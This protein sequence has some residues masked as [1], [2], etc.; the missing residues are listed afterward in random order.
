MI[1]K[2]ELAL[3]QSASDSIRGFRT[4]DLEESVRQNYIVPVKIYIASGGWGSY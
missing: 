3:I 1:Q 4:F 2:T